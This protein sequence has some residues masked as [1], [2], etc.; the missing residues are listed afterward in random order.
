MSQVYDIYDL[1]VVRRMI[2]GDVLMAL[3]GPFLKVLFALYCSLLLGTESD[4][5][6][7]H[8]FFSGTGLSSPRISLSKVTTEQAKCKKK[9][10]RNK[11]P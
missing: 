8:V 10:Q 2:S 6:L 7:M 4:L 11:K 9:T 5:A 1:Q 3:V